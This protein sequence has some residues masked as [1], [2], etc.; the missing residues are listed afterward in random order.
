MADPIGIAKFPGIDQIV[1]WSFTLS[2]GITPSVANITIAPQKDFPAI[3]GTLEFLFA[4]KKLEFQDCR[5]DTVSYERNSQGLIWRLSIFDRRW[6]WAFGHISGFYNTPQ[7]DGKVDKKTEKTPQELAELCLK[8]MGETKYSV[9]GLPN[10]TRPQIV[11][12]YDNPSQALASLVEALGCRV[13]L[14]TKNSV[15][16]CKLGDGEKLPVNNDISD[17]AGAIDPPERPDKLLLVGAVER[18]Q[19][20]LKLEAVGVDLDGS[21]KPI[22]DLSYA[23]NDRL[24]GWGEF[25]IDADEWED[26]ED[27]KARRLARESVFRWYRV[28]GHRDGTLNFPSF[29]QDVVIKEID[30]IFPL[31]SERVEQAEDPIDKVKRNLP[32]RIIGEWYRAGIDGDNQE[33]RAS[34]DELEECAELDLPFS[35]DRLRGI[36]IFANPCA[37][38]DDNSELWIPARIYLEC[39]FGI[40][41]KDTRGFRR[42]TRSKEMSGKKFNTKE[43]I[44][45]DDGFAY[46]NRQHYRA[47][48]TTLN[49]TASEA[50][51]NKL[52]DQF[53][54]ESAKEYETTEPREYTYAGLQ[55]I[56]PDGAIHQVTWRGGVGS[57]CMT[58][59]SRNNEHNVYVPSYQERRMLEKNSGINKAKQPAGYDAL[60]INAR[61]F[62]DSQGKQAYV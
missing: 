34:G 9:S 40:R 47:D 52:A 19:R 33:V 35:I 12:D 11:W 31:E 23:P 30:Q 4:S 59:A 14:T 60:T 24:G 61:R 6:K 56:S 15:H 10:T 41:D 13:V 54:S 21:I 36:V 53:L 22:N 7:A 49:V 8:A 32:A 51:V 42:Y 3:G 57:G 1:D 27:C 28:T 29:P 26:I 46:T 45:R 38:F 5:I 58:T 50:E 55:E 20:Q 18:Y 48:G 25:P 16:I 43:R 62:Q 44:Y 17:D 2:H 37:L 39:A